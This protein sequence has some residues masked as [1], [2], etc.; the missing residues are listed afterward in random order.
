MFEKP[1]TLIDYCLRYL[2]G[3]NVNGVLPLD[4]MQDKFFRGDEGF[5]LIAVPWPFSTAS[6]PITAK[7]MSGFWA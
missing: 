4:L 1:L 2:G 6:V 5:Q 3:E 7:G